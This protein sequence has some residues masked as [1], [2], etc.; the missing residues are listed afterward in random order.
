[1]VFRASVYFSAQV[2]P[3]P[4]RVWFLVQEQDRADQVRARPEARDRIR[5]GHVRW[6]VPRDPTFGPERIEIQAEHG[7]L[8]D[9]AEQVRIPSTLVLTKHRWFVLLARLAWTGHGH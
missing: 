6:G 5:R 9:Q 8:Q 1:M 2:H 7:S 3:E 4:E